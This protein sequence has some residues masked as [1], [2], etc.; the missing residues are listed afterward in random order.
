MVEMQPPSQE[1]VMKNC[2]EFSEQSFV[3]LELGHQTM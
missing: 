1:F 2:L 3:A